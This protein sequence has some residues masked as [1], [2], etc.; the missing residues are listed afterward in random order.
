MYNLAGSDD[1]A[2]F[3]TA[4]MDT[5]GDRIMPTSKAYFQ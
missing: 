5:Q 4:W 3:N 1:C 2:T